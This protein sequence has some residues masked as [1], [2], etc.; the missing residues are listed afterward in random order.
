VDAIVPTSLGEGIEAYLLRPDSLVETLNLVFKQIDISGF[1]ADQI[2]PLLDTYG[3]VDYLVAG[4]YT[5]PDFLVGTPDFKTNARGVFDIDR[6]SGAGTHEPASL[7]FLLAVPKRAYGTAPFPVLL[8]CHGYTSMKLEALAFA[9]VMAKYGIATFVI[10]SYSHGIPLGDAL[11]TGLI[12]GI[13]N[14]SLLQLFEAIKKD[15][16]RDLNGDGVVDVGGDFWTNDTFHTRDIV[17]Q[18]AVDYLQAIRVL[19]SFDGHQSW[20]FDLTGNG[21]GTFLAGDFNNDGVVD[22]GGPNA[23]FYVAG[24]S[25]GGIMSSIIGALDPAIVAASPISPG[26]GLLEVG[27][28]TDLGNVVRAVILPILGPMFITEPLGGDRRVQVIKFLVNDVFQKKIINIARV[29]EIT[30]DDRIENEMRA[31]DIFRVENRT[32]GNSDEVIVTLD[33]DD[34]H[35]S[36][37]A[38]VPADIDDELVITIYRPDGAGEALAPGSRARKDSTLVK[39]IDTWEFEEPQFN[40]RKYAIGEKLTAIQEGLGYRRNTPSL[41]RLL[42]ISQMILEPAD[43]VN[44]AP[45]Y[46]KPLNIR[47]EGRRNTKI[48]Y[49]VTLGDMT[50]PVSTGVALSRS[51]GIIPFRDPDPRWDMTANQLLIDRH[52]TEGIDELRYFEFD[53][54]HQGCGQTNFDIDDLSNGNHSGSTMPRNRSVNEDASCGNAFVPDCSD[55][56]CEVTPPLRA[57]VRNGDGFNAVRFPALSP[58]GQHAIDLPNPS[59]S[60]DASMFVIN[61]I[62]LF[63]SSAGT[64]LSDHPCLAENDCSTCRGEAGC[65][66]IPAPT[67]INVHI[68]E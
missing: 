47:P 37:R 16:A 68:G 12:E 39:K 66:S 40:G 62:G 29:G 50:V 38:H 32:N 14:P 4:D 30:E 56:V 13:D 3:A 49:T 55:A 60:F 42:G 8:Y 15:R 54:C 48:L 5:S 51:A 34:R 1:N 9:G 43:P 63:L 44:Y 23:E 67:H 11:L 17:R 58:R 21:T 22:V 33:P 27:L 26:G 59:Q 28:R 31:G 6:A 20:P 46:S 2:E 61:Q 35:L 25:M 65:P 36:I 41:R 52:V 18:T 45:R 64:V 24:T 19:Q 10:D 53:C 7:R 57:T